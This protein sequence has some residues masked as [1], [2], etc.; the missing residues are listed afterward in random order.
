MVM[1]LGSGLSLTMKGCWNSSSSLELSANRSILFCDSRPFIEISLQ[2]LVISSRLSP[3]LFIAIS[4][5]WSIP[6]KSPPL[7]RIFVAFF[8]A[9]S[10]SLLLF[11]MDL[12]FFSAL[13]LFF[14]Y[15]SSSACLLLSLLSL[16]FAL[17]RLLLLL[18]R[19]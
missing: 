7:F 3:P 9:I 19:L 6:M 15:L 17:L 5:V 14:S 2:N 13:L 12:S 11:N 16:L 18:D 10:S 8:F 1:G 4:L